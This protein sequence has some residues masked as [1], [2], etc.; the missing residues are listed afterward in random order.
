MTILDVPQNRIKYRLG[1]FFPGVHMHT[2]IDKWAVNVFKLCTH[3]T[4]SLS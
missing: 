2:K 1:K 3:S 4:G